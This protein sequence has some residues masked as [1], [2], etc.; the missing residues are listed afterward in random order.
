MNDVYARLKQSQ[1]VKRALQFLFE[2]DA[3]VLKEQIELA[4]IPAPPFTEEARAEDYEKRL[5]SLGLED[6]TSDMEGNVYGWQKGEGKGPT[7]FVSAHLD[8]VF[9]ADVDLTVTEKAGVYYGP[10]ITDD[11][12]GLAALLS[13]I[14]ACNEAGLQT[15]GD[16]IF[17]GTVG[18]EGPGD[19]RGVKAFFREHDNV[20]GFI[21]IDAVS[22]S[23]IIYKGTG[24]YRYTITFRGPGGHSFG[25]FGTPSAVHAAARATTAIAELEVETDPKT[26]FNV[27]VIEGGTIPTAIAQTCSIGVD[28]RS[29]GKGELDVLEKNIQ[30]IV[31]QA[32]NAENE[33]WGYT[34]DHGISSSIEK[35]GDRPVARQAEDDIIVRTAWQ[36]TE[37]L[38]LQPKLSKAVSTDAN[39]PIS[40]GIPSLTLGGGGQA[41][42]AHSL[43]EWY[44]PEKSYLGPQRVLLTMLGLVGLYSDGD[45]IRPLLAK[46]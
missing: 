10:G 4:E 46:R 20:D 8:S 13:L 17:G 14:R 12:R 42:A 44:Q 7:L 18:E 15:I 21:S 16:I 5:R 23:E 43:D 11:A 39:Y 2:D 36:A 31:E 9:S 45:L 27:G 22:P 1:Q 28:I 37:T 19:L 3:R 38:S 26:T 29:N 25:S 34:E 24:S 40:I 33:R 35:I 30:K 6:V 41:G 32:M